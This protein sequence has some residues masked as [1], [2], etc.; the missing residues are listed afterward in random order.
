MENRT[1]EADEYK[2]NIY[3]STVNQPR[4]ESYREDRE[5]IADLDE[6]NFKINGAE[7]PLTC[8]ASK[9]TKMN[10][11]YGKFFLL[12]LTQD[13]AN[14]IRTKILTGIRKHMPIAHANQRRHSREYRTF[15]H[16]IQN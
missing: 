2:L 14:L 6:G 12:F 3:S 7:K 11:R 15:N 13:N 1:V 10:D 4:P 9:K 5:D 8:Y 16:V